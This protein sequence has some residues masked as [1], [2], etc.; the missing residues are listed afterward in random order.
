MGAKKIADVK[1]KKRMMLSMEMK[2]EIIKKYEA[3][4]RLSVLAKEYGRNPSTI[5]TTLKEAIKAATHSK[6]V[7][8]FSN[9]RSHLYDEME[10]LLLVWI[11]DK[12]MAGDIITEA[13]ICQKAS[14]IFNDL[15]RAQADADAGE[16]TSKQEPPE[17]KAS[18]G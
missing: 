1:G 5:G 16:G 18:H 11:K 14:A 4:M 15:V 10:R 7:T 17:F 2:M 6:G 3:G 9:K 12:E 8:V 13:I